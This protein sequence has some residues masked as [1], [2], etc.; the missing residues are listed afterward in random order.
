MAA[1]KMGRIALPGVVDLDALDLV[2]DQ[3]IEALD[4]G[5]VEID[6]AQ[7][8]RVATNALFMLLSAAQ[9]ARRNRVALVVTGASLALVNAIERLG[10]G[11]QFADVLKG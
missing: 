2:R 4:A 9:T 7:V 11:A 6:G 1:A 5:S 10:L 3:L 8:E